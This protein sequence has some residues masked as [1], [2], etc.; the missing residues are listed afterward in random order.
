MKLSIS[1]C[2][3]RKSRT[4]GRGERADEAEGPGRVRRVQQCGERSE[5]GPRVLGEV[6]RAK[7]EGRSY[8][9][10]L[11]RLTTELSNGRADIDS[12]STLVVLDQAFWGSCFGF[13]RVGGSP[14]WMVGG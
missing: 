13:G 12:E 10:D 4:T 14:W 5:M 3:S 8:K 9:T 11:G 2:L 7:S 6:A 1:L